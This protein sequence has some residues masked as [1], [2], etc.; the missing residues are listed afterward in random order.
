MIANNESKQ[1]EV[2]QYETDHIHYFSLCCHLRDN[3]YHAVRDS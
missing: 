2:V 1:E 3:L